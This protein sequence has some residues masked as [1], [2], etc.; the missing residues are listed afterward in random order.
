[1]ENFNKADAVESLIKQFL[2]SSQLSGGNAVYIEELYEQYLADPASIPDQWQSY[3]ADFKGAGDIPH[4][5]V[6]ASVQAQARQARFN[7]GGGDEEMA[8]K[9]TAVGKLVTAYRSRGHLLANLDPL[10][11]ADKPSAPDLE[12]ANYGLS[13]NDLQ[14]EFPASTYFGPDKFKLSDLLGRLKATY[15][16]SI[17]VEFMHIS[18]RDQRQWIQQRLESVQSRLQADKELKL[19]IL[20]RLTA[21]EGLE[22]YLHT[23]Y[24]GQKRFSLEGGESLIPLMDQLIQHGGKNGIKDAIIG[25]AHRGRLNVLVN[26]LGK[27]PQKLFAEFEGRFEHP[28]TP[29]HSGDVKYHMGFSADINTPGGPVHLALAFNPSHLEI[30]APVVAGSVKARQMRRQDDDRSQVL[31]VV[32]HGDAAFAGQGVVMELFQMSQARGFSVGGTVHIVINNQV[33]FTTSRPDDARSTLYCT[34]PAKIVGAPVLHVNGDDPEAVVFCAELAFD[35]RRTFGRDIVI[36]LVCY[37]RHGHNEADEPAATQPLMYQNIR[38]RKTT[39]ELYAQK[40]MASDI[41]S[42]DQNKMM[43]D[44]FRSKLDRGEVTTDVAKAAKDVYAV[45]WTPWLHGKLGQVIKTGLPQ[46]SLDNLGRKIS[47]VPEGFKL[48]ARVAKIYEDRR[49][50]AA[51]ELDM[52]WGFAENLAYASLLTEGYRLR[53]VGQDA[54][55]GTFFHRHAVL[56]EQNTGASYMPL[57]QFVKQPSHAVIID[58]LLSEEAVMAFEYGYSTAEPMT[59]N[60]WEG[61]FGDFANGAQVVID[62]FITSGEAKWDRLCGLVLFLPHGYEGQGPEHSSARLERFLQLSALNNIQVCTP[63][64]PAQMFHMLR[65]QMLSATR[66]PLVVMTP[67][68]MLRHKLS[69]SRMDDLANGNFQEL[70]PDSMVNSPDKASRVVICA[71]KVYYDLLAAAEERK[72][73]NVAIVRIEQLYPFPRAALRN[74]LNRFKNAKDIVWCQEEP[75]NQ[76]AWYQIQHHL[77]SCLPEGRILHY[78]GRARSAAPACGHAN[79]HAA[80]E[81]KLLADALVNPGQ[82]DFTHE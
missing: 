82:R 64:T 7:T 74:E 2:K 56:H 16:S 25:M 44:G 40:L 8:L 62:Q 6:L 35:Y 57:Q 22:R 67:K 34:D 45:D 79:T 9:Q 65:R 54:G 29:E 39:R 58:S 27:P 68:S 76:G 13:V 48:Q 4:S 75:Q 14:R 3:F 49:K 33:G 28:D 15:S 80:E 5:A 52:D 37:R 63:T 24:V 32:I 78:A 23:K 30:V 18:D 72:L 70:I 60:I 21:A 50:M 42:E 69:V 73:E 10:G 53:L 1:L 19:H 61:Q 41:L 47:T 26:T 17:G 77:R 11:M 51:G 66:K 12:L 20:E 46:F 71:G 43:I 38:A 81:A 59:L 31:P 55:R 36:D